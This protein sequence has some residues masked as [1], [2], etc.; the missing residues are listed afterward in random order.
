[1]TY[2]AL[3]AV[4]LTVGYMA[5][6]SWSLPI[7]HGPSPKDNAEKSGDQSDSESEGSEDSF[8]EELGSVKASLFE[9][10]KL[11]SI[12]PSSCSNSFGGTS[13]LSKRVLS[14]FHDNRY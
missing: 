1:M 12:N 10:T 7:S 4:S 11:A 3:A 14:P 2:A 6:V 5:G 8:A 13:V 9:E